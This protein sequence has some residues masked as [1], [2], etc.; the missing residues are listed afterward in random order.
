MDRQSLKEQ[1]NELLSRREYDEVE[2]LLTE[3]G[4][5][6]KSDRDLLKVYYM[7]PVCTAEKEAGQRTLF[8]KV[9]S[10]EELVE[11]ETRLKFYLRRIAFD[12]L[13]DEEAFYEYCAQNRV[14]LPELFVVTYCGAVHREK[15]QAFIQRK[16][17]EGKL[18]V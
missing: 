16:I 12:L 11:R 10:V 6:A 7:L 3:Y 13:E 1:I 8:A 18:R 9:S 5:I 14:S 15:V 4:D 17:A 2:S